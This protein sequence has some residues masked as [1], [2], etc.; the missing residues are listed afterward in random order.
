VL[1][2]RRFTVWAGDVAELVGQNFAVTLT[3]TTTNETTPLAFVAE[4][5]TYWGDGWFGGHG[6]L[7]VA[8]R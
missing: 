6:S 8:R 1:P 5:V 2:G 4:R 3:G 7:G